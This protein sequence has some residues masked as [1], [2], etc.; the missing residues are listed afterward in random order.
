[1]LIRCTVTVEYHHTKN[2]WYTCL[3]GPKIVIV[4]Y[5]ERS[6]HIAASSYMYLLQF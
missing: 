2:H 4:E 6:E 1:M 3:E 5:H